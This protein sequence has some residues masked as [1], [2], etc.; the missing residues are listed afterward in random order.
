MQVLDDQSFAIMV[1]I[2]VVKT[3]IIIPIVTLIYKPA[4]KFA[5]Y[6]KRTVQRSKPDSEF[7]VLVC[8]HTPRN[9]PTIINLLEA[10][11]PTKKSPICIYVLHLVELSGRA[12][13]M[14]I[15]HNSRKSADQPSIELKHNHII[16][17]T[18]SK[19]LS[20]MLAVFQSNL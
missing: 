17:S 11:H 10:S 8:V 19:I 5:P 12:S 7:R 15:V 16:L 3:S 1:I 18:H 9:V 20:S 2:S 14:L 13:A 6:K 4:R